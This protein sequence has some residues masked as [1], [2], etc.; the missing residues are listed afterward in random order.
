MNNQVNLHFSIARTLQQIDYINLLLCPW[1]SY[2]AS[3]VCTQLMFCALWLIIQMNFNAGL[4]PFGVA[5]AY[6]EVLLTQVLLTK[7]LLSYHNLGYLSYGKLVTKHPR[8]TFSA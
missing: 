6:K 5:V 8:G 3:V 1:Q 4:A 7:V 2:D